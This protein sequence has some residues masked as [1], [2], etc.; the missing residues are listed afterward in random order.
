MCFESMAK[1]EFHFYYQRGPGTSIFLFRIF[2]LKCA[3]VAVERGGPSEQEGL[4][5]LL[6]K[7]YL[8]PC[9]HPAPSLRHS[10]AAALGPLGLM[11]AKD[12][13]TENSGGRK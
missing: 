9:P 4:L 10:G 1:V 3:F 8:S 12:Y 13:K 7:K 6:H 5:L 2:F 11:T